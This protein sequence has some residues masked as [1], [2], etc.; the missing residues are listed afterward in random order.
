MTAYFEKRYCQTCCCLHWVEVHRNGRETCHGADY[1]PHSDSSH[2]TRRS[3]RGFEVIEK[4]Q[5]LPLEWDILA[6]SR[7]LEPEVEF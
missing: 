3:G 6:Q 1:H 2:Y 7:D 5:E 4:L